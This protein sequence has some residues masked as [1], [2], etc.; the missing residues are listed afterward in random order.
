MHNTGFLDW[1]FCKLSGMLNL[2]WQPPDLES[3]QEQWFKT[4]EEGLICMTEKGVD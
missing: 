4:H 2:P 3:E 1:R